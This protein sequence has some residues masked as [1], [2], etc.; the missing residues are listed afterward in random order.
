[1][2][3]MHLNGIVVVLAGFATAAGTGCLKR[4]EGCLDALLCD[5][6]EAGGGGGGSTPQECVPSKSSEAVND[7]CGVFVAASGDDA[8][9][10]TK[11]AP[12]KTIQQAVARAQ[13]EGAARRVYACA[14]TFEGQVELPGGVTLFGGLD[15]STDWR[16]LG[17]TKTILTAPE[18]EIPL[19]MRGG[20][21][22]VRV[23][24]VHVAAR[25]IDPSN[26]AAPGAS[27]IA[28]LAESIAVEMARCTLEAGDAADGRDGE[29][30]KEPAH[31]GEQGNPGREACSGE[32]VVPGGVKRNECGTPD[33]PSDDSTG[34]LGGIGTLAE[35]GAGSPGGPEGAGGLGGA[36]ERTQE[37]TAGTAGDDGLPGEPGPNAT[38]LGTL[39]SSGYAGLSGTAGS[40]GTTAQGGGGGGGAKGGSAANQ[41][42]PESAG[43]ASGGSGGPG[44]CGGKGGN[45]GGPGGASI[46]L[47]SLDA[48][49][50]FDDVLLKTGRGG[51]G[52]N[53]GP[54]QEGGSGGLGGPGGT[55]PAGIEGL[56]P[57]CSGGPG[58]KG[59]NGGNGGGGLGGHSLGIAYR[60]KPPPSR[61]FSVETGEAGPGGTGAG[62]GGA[63]G[64]RADTQ[65]FAP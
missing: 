17:E 58:G 6:G 28:A 40:P 24:D 59:G 27:S 53:G 12:V 54:G 55:V 56:Q 13:Q 16:W 62:D 18:G 61:G 57:G 49:L 52:G 25:A 34:G 46:A 35:G 43:G 33:Y 45:P 8:A 37:C 63:A 41:C 32:I 64:L 48:E 4:S 36:G 23:E 50:T 15:C 3:R 11:A 20:D 29:P 42:T 26:E 5:F 21:G 47:V 7:G 60:G 14:E 2:R 30:Y 38:G 10:G 1:M 19:V 9:A 31:A 44:G 39:S 65:E 22:A 51:R